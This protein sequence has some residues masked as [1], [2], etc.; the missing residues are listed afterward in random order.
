MILTVS[1]STGHG[2][3]IL[4]SGTDKDH[5]NTEILLDYRVH[6]KSVTGQHFDKMEGKTRLPQALLPSVGVNTKR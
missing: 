6:Q 2:L 3:R 1:L 4:H 5:R